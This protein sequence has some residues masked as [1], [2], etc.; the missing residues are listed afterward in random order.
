MIRSQILKLYIILMNLLNSQKLKYLKRVYI[1]LQ[2][3]FPSVYNRL[4]FH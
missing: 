1:V 2:A 3:S 4:Q